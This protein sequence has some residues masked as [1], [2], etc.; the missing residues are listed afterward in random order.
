MPSLIVTDKEI[1]QCVDV[2]ES[3]LV[4]LDREQEGI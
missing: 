3:V 2:L 4:V 1:E